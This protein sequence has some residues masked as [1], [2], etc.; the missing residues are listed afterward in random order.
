MPN[1]KYRVKHTILTGKGT[2]CV[3]YWTWSKS[4]TKVEEAVLFTDKTMP[5]FFQDTLNHGLRTGC[6]VKDYV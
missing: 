1:R 5:V 4:T 6:I 3:D 2:G